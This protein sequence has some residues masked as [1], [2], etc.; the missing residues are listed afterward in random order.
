MFG[1][2]IGI[3]EFV[4]PVKIHPK[5]LNGVREDGI[6]KTRQSQTRKFDSST[7]LSKRF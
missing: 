2:K 3:E 7:S 5:K 6:A 1:K 4:K